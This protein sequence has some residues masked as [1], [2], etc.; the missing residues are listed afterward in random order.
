VATFLAEPLDYAERW[1]LDG[2]RVL[3]PSVS[4]LQATVDMTNAL[5]VLEDLRRG[6]VVASA[7]HLLVKA[8][9]DAFAKNPDLH[10]LVAGNRR[11]HAARVDIGLSVTGETFIT[12]VLVIEGADQKA[13]AEIAAETSR[14]VPEA[15]SADR[16]MRQLLK[17]WGWLVPIGALRRGILRLLYT[18]AEFRRKAAGTFQI[19]TVAGDWA[20]TSTFAGS[21]VLFGGLVKSRV[22]AIDGQPAVRPTMTLTLCGD[23]AVWDGRAAARFLAGVKSNL[24]V[25]VQKNP[26]QA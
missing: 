4:V 22:V 9:A 18:R 13:V 12:P 21:G 1:M 26:P 24:E 20:F 7:T 23:H 16:Q 25:A 17:R 15:Q 8:A 14:R 6:G 3:R 11:Y 19:S 10:Q 5:L 2:L